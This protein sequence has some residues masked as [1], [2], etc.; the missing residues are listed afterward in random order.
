MDAHDEAVASIARHIKHFHS[1]QQ[2]FRISHGS[3]NSTRPIAKGTALISTA[4]LNHVLRVDTSSRTALVEPNVPMDAL[5]SATMKH[6]LLPPIVMEFPGI[7]VGGG[8]AGT[9]GES[10]SFKHGFFNDTLNWVELVLGD[11]EITRASPTE[12]ADLFY[13][14][15]GAC[16]TL[17]VTTLVEIQLIL[18]SKFVETTYHRVTSI[19]EALSAM[20]KLAQESSIDY[21]DGI[22][23]SA[24]NGAIISGRLT[25]TPLFSSEE[26]SPPNPPTRSFTK[27]TDPWYYQHVQRLTAATLTNN[28]LTS[29]RSST[30]ESIPPNP[31]KSH[32]T[33]LIPTHSYLFRYDRAGFWVG[34]S[35]FAYF[36]GLIPCTPLTRWLLDDFMRT[37]MMYAAL[38]ASGYSDRYLVQDCA[39]PWDKAEE[40]T[41][42]CD[43]ETGIWPLWLCPLRRPTTVGAQ[44]TFHPSERDGRGEWRGMLNIGLWGKPPASAL[45]S[46]GSWVAFNRLIERKLT[47]LGG[48]KWLYA[49]SYYPRGE[50]WGIYGWEWY[51]KLREKYK[52]TGLP[53][54]HQKVSRDIE[55]EARR[56]GS[57]KAWVLGIWPLAGLYG[58][59]AAM[60]SREFLK[61]RGSWWWKDGWE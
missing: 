39:V 42:W 1:R 56:D 55:G 38:H 6:G 7:T 12:R 11:G 29:S 53:D 9:S 27:A 36:L 25:D 60:G 33:D 50:F 22:L 57:W 32:H 48:R 13:G 5:V 15:A 40:F 20:K 52:A 49:H 59:V 35:T 58:V 24:T 46:T 18:A 28:E 44:G 8:F 19:D 61:A 43:V 10:S 54:V 30:S 31:P 17:G 37:R 41:K 21:L 34:R 2:P 23:F 3:T 51:S 45:K 4:S 14:A 26:H 47:E 16:G